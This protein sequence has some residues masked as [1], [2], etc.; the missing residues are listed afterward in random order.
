MSLHRSYRLNLRLSE[1]E[2]KKVNRLYA[3]STCR[4]ISEYARKLLTNQPVNVF[5]RNPAPRD[6]LFLVQPLMDCIE[7][8][9][10]SMTNVDLAQVNDF[11]NIMEVLEDIRTY[12]AKLSGLCDPK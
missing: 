1:T 3:N 8:A 9:A 11:G 6:L 5:F 7:L 4:S 12:L 2:W 10:E